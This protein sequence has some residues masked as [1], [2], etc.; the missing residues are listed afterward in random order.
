MERRKIF[1][2]LKNGYRQIIIK[3]CTEV[4]IRELWERTAAEKKLNL[5]FQ[6]SERLQ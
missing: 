4:K 1:G 3:N 6:N 5:I 2:G